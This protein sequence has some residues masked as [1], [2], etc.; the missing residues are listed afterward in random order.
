LSCSG[1]TNRL[2]ASRITAWFVSHQSQ[3]GELP[4]PR[5]SPGARPGTR[6]P[7]LRISALLPE[8][9]EPRTMYQGSTYSAAPP[10]SPP[11]SRD[12]LSAAIA[13]TSSFR[14]A[15]RARRSSAV[16]VETEASAS[17]IIDCSISSDP[18]FFFR[19]ATT[20]TARAIAISRTMIRSR[21]RPGSRP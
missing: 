20:I 11:A 10:L 5:I 21:T 12:F 2:S 19:A 3:C 7:E 6:R 8:S 17:W 15:S 9:P 18:F 16:A 4:I 13:A 1:S 14:A